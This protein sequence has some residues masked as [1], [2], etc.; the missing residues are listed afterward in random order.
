MNSKINSINFWVVGLL[1]IIFTIYFSSLSFV[2]FNKKHVFRK[3]FK[4]YYCV[5]MIKKKK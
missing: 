3:N 2:C 4:S 5:E 1:E